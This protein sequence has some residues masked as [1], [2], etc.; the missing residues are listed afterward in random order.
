MWR[1]Q[2]RWLLTSGESPP[3]TLPLTNVSS[4]IPVGVHVTLLDNQH[5]ITG[6]EGSATP[7]L[8][9]QTEKSK[10]PGAHHVFFLMDECILTGC[11]TMAQKQP[12]PLQEDPAAYSEGCPQAPWC[13]T[14]LP[15]KTFTSPASLIKAV[16]I[17]ADSTHPLPPPLQPPATREKVPE[18]Q[19]FTP[20]L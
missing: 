2:R 3:C 17:A 14:P 9:Q 13:P 10:N 5:H 18:E 6:W 20:C 12:W 11:I 16:S 19:L 1:K 15:S 8:P 4:A 7:R